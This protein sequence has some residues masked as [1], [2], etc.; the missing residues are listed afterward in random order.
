MVSWCE[1][2]CHACVVVFYAAL[3]AHKLAQYRDCV[4]DPRR[5]HGCDAILTL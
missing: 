3:A 4:Q 5:W 1:L 2:F